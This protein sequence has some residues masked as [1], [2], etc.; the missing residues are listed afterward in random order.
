MEKH[1]A[2]YLLNNCFSSKKDMAAALGVSYS[3]LLRVFRG[4]SSIHNNERIMI[5]MA[6]YCL[7]KRIPPQELF[8][9]F[10]PM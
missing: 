9:G 4:E 7:A 2:E 3:A 10:A 8:H 6:L 5:R 1:L